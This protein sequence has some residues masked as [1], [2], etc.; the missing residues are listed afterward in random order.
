MFNFARTLGK[1]NSSDHWQQDNFKPS[2]RHL[3][4]GPFMEMSSEL[5]LVIDRK[6]T[7]IHANTALLHK[8]EMSGDELATR[9]FIDLFHEDDRA[10][11]RQTIQNLVPTAGTME[12][13]CVTFQSRINAPEG[14]TYWINWKAFG[15][16]QNTYCIGQDVTEHYA[17]HAELERNRNQLKQAESI[18]RLGRWKWQVG[19]DTINWSEELYRIWDVNPDHFTPNFANMY[20]MLDED[21]QDRMDQTLQRAVINK[22][23]FDVD[24]CLRMPHGEE[25]YIRCEGRCAL[26]EEGHVTSLYGIM[27]DMTEWMAYERELKSAK[28]AAERAYAA[29]T[30]FLANMSHELRTPLNAIIG[31]SEMIQSQMFG[32]LGSEKYVDY[33]GDIRQSGAHLLDLI[34]DIL[35]MSKIEAGKYDL[36]LEEV[37]IVDVV[38]TAIKM[39]TTRAR[40]TGIMITLKESF[41]PATIMVADRRAC[42]QILLNILSNAVKF[43]NKGGKIELVCQSGKDKISIRIR[44]YG[45]GIPANKLATI[46]NPFEQVSPHYTREHEGSGLGLAITKELVEMHGGTMKIESQI[47]V[48]TTVTINMPVLARP[49]DTMDLLFKE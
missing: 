30:Q 17:L 16:D 43:S 18:G 28:E 5:M 9:Q 29:K 46:T 13:P 40:E 24:F 19:E 41:S 32:P 4:F 14:R 34:S 3:D 44:D 21:D 12:S 48:G 22:N 27:Q 39:V 37:Q 47:G 35:D 38:E 23:N 8:L 31:F 15:H 20:E 1:K 11:I 10:N 26:D 6:N 25:R 33:A 7:L 2:A 45:I 42:L 49:K 36:D